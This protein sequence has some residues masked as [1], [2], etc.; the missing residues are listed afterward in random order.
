MMID[1][2]LQSDIHLIFEIHSIN[3]CITLKIHLL[4]F[5]VN[6][7]SVHL[8]QYKCV[9][10]IILRPTSRVFYYKSCLNMMLGQS[11]MRQSNNDLLQNN[12]YFTQHMCR[13]ECELLLRVFDPS[14][15][16]SRR[17]TFTALCLLRNIQAKIRGDA[18]EHSEP[19][20]A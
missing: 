1:R 6:M 15:S 17:H 20:A 10:L 7:K 18:A 4:Q 3:L 5:F 8:I 19:T 13:F 12:L 9:P 16:A 14:V 11:E 2:P